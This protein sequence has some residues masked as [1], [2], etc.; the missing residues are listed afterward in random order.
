MEEW[1]KSMCKRR[2]NQVGF[3][4]QKSLFLSILLASFNTVAQEVSPEAF[5]TAFI[6][7]ALDKITWQNED[8]FSTYRVGITGRSPNLHRAL[9]EAS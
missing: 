7:H 1:L 5:K 4:V 8:Q 3:F 2:L 9:S 6:F